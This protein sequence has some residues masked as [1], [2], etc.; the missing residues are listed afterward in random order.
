M[1]SIKTIDYFYK[2]A[3][4]IVELFDEHCQN[5]RLENHAKVDHFGL[6]TSSH[7]IY[8]ELREIFS[9]HSLFI[10]ESIISNR[11]ISIIKLKIPLQT[12]LGVLHFLEL[13]DQKPDGSQIDIFDHFEIVPQG[14][15]YKELVGLVKASGVNLRENNKIHHSTFDIVLPD[16]VI[17]LSKQMLIDK[18]KNEEII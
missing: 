10:Y 12:K 13:S 17:K 18:I 3:K 11:P 7:S 14:M 15:V 6:R 1:K 4:K 5:L 2:E 8:L 16:M 9:G